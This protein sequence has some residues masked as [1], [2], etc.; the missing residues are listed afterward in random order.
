MLKIK[1]LMQIGA[2]SGLKFSSRFRNGDLTAKPNYDPT[3]PIITTTPSG[4]C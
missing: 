3:V 4:V 2:S 1:N